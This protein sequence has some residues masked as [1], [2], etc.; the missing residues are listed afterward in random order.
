M[1]NADLK[2]Q[3]QQLLE[4][5]EGDV[6]FVASLG[7]DDKS[8]ELKELLNE[9][10]EMSAHITIT[11]KSLKRTPSFSVNR[12][13]EETGITFAGIPLGHE[14]NSLVLAILQVSGRAPKEKQSIIDQIKGLEGPFHFETFVSLTCQKCPDVVQALNLMSVINPNIT[15]TMIDGAVFREESEN[16]MAVPAVFLDGQEFG[17]GRMTVQDILT[18]L[19]STQ[20]ASEFN[21]K[22]PY[23][24]LIVGGADLQVVVL[25]FIQ[26]VKG[27]VQVLS[28]IELVV[29]L[30]ILLVSRTSS[31]LK[32]RQVQ[33]SHQILQNILHNMILIQ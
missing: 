18:K 20:D 11:E 23:D 31:L 16:I 29:K 5:M 2:Q 25:Q 14:F 8:N 33:S 19:G 26:H 28:L 7:S 12:P 3:L 6:E 13:G 17:N 9:I 1:L 10:A 30:M 32:K 27:Y 22:D 21:D 24:V 15:H 4:L